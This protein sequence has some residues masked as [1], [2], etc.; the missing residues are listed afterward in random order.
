MSEEATPKKRTRR[1]STKRDPRKVAIETVIIE[2]S[3]PIIEEE[4][5]AEAAEAEIPEVVEVEAPAPEEGVYRSFRRRRN[6]K[7]NRL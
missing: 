6:I 7:R 3:D 4:P 5:S 1:K 2:P